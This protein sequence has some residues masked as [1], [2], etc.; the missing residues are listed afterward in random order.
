MLRRIAVV[1]AMFAALLLPQAAVAGGGGHACFGPHGEVAFSDE[2][3]T[4]V[5]L[6]DNCF[7]ANVVRVNAGDTVTWRSK[8]RF[9]HTVSGVANV[10]G[11]F[12]ELRYNDEVSYRFDEEG[13]FPYF[14]AYHPGMVG[15]VVVGDGFGSGGAAAGAIAP[16]APDAE[17]VSG[18]TAPETDE[19]SAVPLYLAVGLAVLIGLG[20]IASFFRT[21]KRAE[22]APQ[23]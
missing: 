19:G 8:D 15:A 7:V 16:V 14:C 9:P 3:A 11:T 4:T 5:V 21:R 23:L 20:G 17:P 12:G 22:P 2:Q 18:T 10:F 6:K 1:A 13:T